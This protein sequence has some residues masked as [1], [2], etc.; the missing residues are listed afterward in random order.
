MLGSGARL[1]RQ[2]A[3]R[4][5]KIVKVQAAI[6][7]RRAELMEETKFGTEEVIENLR[8]AVMFDPRKRANEGGTVK[9]RRERRRR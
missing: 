8:Q 6:A 2:Q 1:N 5:L 3:S 9:A 4:L 7:A